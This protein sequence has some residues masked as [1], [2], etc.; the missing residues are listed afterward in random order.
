[1]S[2]VGINHFS[3]TISPS[4]LWFG[5]EWFG[6]PE[7]ISKSDVLFRWMFY[8]G[9]VIFQFWGQINEYTYT[10][11]HE[12]Y[13]RRSKLNVKLWR[14]EVKS[15]TVPLLASGCLDRRSVKS[16][17][18]SSKFKLNQGFKQHKLTFLE[19]KIS[20]QYW[21]EVFPFQTLTKSEFRGFC[22]RFHGPTIEQSNAESGTILCLG[23]FLP[24]SSIY[25][26]FPYIPG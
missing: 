14:K 12:Q 23:T 7:Q 21:E 17:I 13:V 2:A 19:Q 4:N 16:R 25:F 3:L 5:C 15:G 18:K 6:K 20:L 22:P 26:L 11:I 9:V 24:E 1:M 8:F 10:N